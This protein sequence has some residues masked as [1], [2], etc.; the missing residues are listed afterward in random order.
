MKDLV[1]EILLDGGEILLRGG[2]VARLEIGAELVEGLG[3]GVGSGGKMEAVEVVPEVAAGCEK[4]ACKVAKSDCAAE[5]LP[6]WRAWLSCC[7]SC[8]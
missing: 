5:R 8:W 7:M 2:K 4:A 1:L 3:D 6:D